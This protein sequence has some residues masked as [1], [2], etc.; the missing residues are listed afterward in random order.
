VLLLLDE[1]TTG[2]DPRSK[3]DVQRFVRALRN[4]HDATILLCTHDM[5]EA[6]E[7]CDRIAL[8]DRGRLVALDTVEGLKR[9]VGAEM[10]A[11]DPSLDDVFL[12]LT[13][14]SLGDD[15]DEEAEE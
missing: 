12:H 7:L 6:E 4:D 13:G 1:P 15:E 8:I 2:L 9:T 14:R 11:V 10:G 5:R 3:Q